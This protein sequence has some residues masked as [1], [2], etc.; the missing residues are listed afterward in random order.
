MSKQSRADGYDGAGAGAGT[1][2]EKSP[3]QDEVQRQLQMVKRQIDLE[4]AD[5][6]AK[7]RAELAI[8]VRA[9]VAAI[10]GE[11]RNEVSR[12]TADVSAKVSAQVNAQVSAQVSAGVNNAL[13]VRGGEES[14]ANR[15]LVVATCKQLGT[16]VY[17]RVLGELNET[18]VP[19]IDNLAEWMNYQTQDTTELITDYRRAVYDQNRPADQRLITDGKG[20]S[21]TRIRN[22]VDVFFS[23]DD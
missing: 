5:D 18:L 3:Y 2:G 8:M 6:I 22:N 10:R 16:A 21:R 4:L 1:R 7:L 19:K 12:A 23:E 11:I 14:R 20:N 13:A 17:N 9:E 15:E